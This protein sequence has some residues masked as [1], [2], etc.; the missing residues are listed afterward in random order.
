MDRQERTWDLP[1]LLLG[2]LIGSAA[3]LPPELSPAG[4]A[5]AAALAAG[6]GVLMV[7]PGGPHPVLLQGW[8]LPVTVLAVYLPVSV[9]SSSQPHRALSFLLGA[10][11]SAVAFAAAYQVSARAE[12]RE[13]ILGVAAVAGSLAAVWGI[14]QGIFGLSDTARFLRRLGQPEMDPQIL[15]AESGRAFGP[16]LLPSSLGI[17][18]AMSIPL[19]VRFGMR[20]RWRGWRGCLW[21][22]LL[23]LQM[24]GMGSC[25]SYGAVVSLVAAT[26]LLLPQ[27]PGKARPWILPSL[28]GAAVLAGGAILFLRGGEGTSPLLLRAGNWLAAWRVFLEEPC[29]GAGFGSFAD[30]Y[31]KQMI[32]GMNE[33]AYVHNS[34]LQIA[35]EGGGLAL[36]WL[37]AGVTLLLLRIL[38][39]AGQEK[40]GMAELLTAIPPLAFLVHNLFD[41]SAYLPS[42]AITFGAVAGA[43]VPRSLK[44]ET[45]GETPARAGS[46]QR[47]ALLLLL[48]GGAAWQLREAWVRQALDEGRAMLERGRNEEGI[49]LLRRAAAADASNPDPPALLAEVYLSK[50]AGDIEARNAG[51]VFARRAVE[52]RPRRA[53]GHYILATYRLA[54]GDRGEAWAEIARARALFPGRELYLREEERLRKMI[55]EGPGTGPRREPDAGR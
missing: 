28:I 12:R 40:R 15:R 49:S 13:R 9:L 21:A 25:L 17:F 41:F 23:F 36:A 22:G 7:A 20:S 46:L 55:S 37:F 16:F 45:M 27:I 8:P 6:V 1:T 38:R 44:E 52:L 54:A 24:A 14:Y 47:G 18:L 43:A 50:M 31:P 19:T 11:L 33:T 39:R 5:L 53:Y 10:G 35:A 32:A 51:E 48:L 26:F 42:L 3:L 30:A 4:L 2:A 29:F 34:Y